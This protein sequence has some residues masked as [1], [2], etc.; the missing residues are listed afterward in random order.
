[1][2]LNI[3]DIVKNPKAPQLGAGTIVDRYDGYIDVVFDGNPDKKTFKLQNNPLQ[4]IDGANST[5]TNIIGENK[6]N[7]P[8]VSDLLR[9]RAERSE[10]DREN[11][12]KI[13]DKAS[14]E[15]RQ[16]TRYIER[17]KLADGPTDWYRE[18]RDHETKS[19]NSLRTICEEPFHAMVEVETY[20]MDR[21]VEVAKEQL[22]YANEN[23]NCNIPFGIDGKSINVLS[24]THPGVQMALAGDL[25]AP[26]NIRDRNYTLLEVIPLARAKFSQVLPDIVGLYEPGGSV[27]PEKHE[28]ASTVLRAVKL[29]MTHDQVKAF[30]SK[31]NGMM[32]VS[33]APGSGKTTVAMQRIRFLFDQGEMRG[34][35][36]PKVEYS[37]P[38]TRIFLANQNLFEHSRQMLEQDLRIPSDVV[39]LVDEFVGD[40]LKEIWIH[41]DS[42]KIRR[43]ELF[44]MEERGRQAFFGLCNSKQLANCWATYE[45]QISE[46]LSKARSSSWFDISQSKDL[47]FE[48]EYLADGF[49]EYAK[50]PTSFGPAESRFDMDS[51]YEYVAKTYENSRNECR[52]E[53]I[54]EKFDSEFQKWLYWVYDPLDGIVSYFQEDFYEGLVRVKKGIGAK[55]HEDDILRGIRQDW[56][57]RVY[58]KEQES[59]LAFLLRFALPTR[60]DV[61]KR[62]REMPNPLDVAYYNG[63]RWTHV[64]I[65]EAQ[66]LC[67]AQAALI[68]SF[69]H[70]DGAFTVSADFHQVVS[71]VWGMN[72]PEAFKMGISL[73]DKGAYQA[74]P[75]AKNMRQSKQIGLFLQ[76]FFEKNFGEMAR[77]ETNDS[78]QDAPPLLILAKAGE[79]PE[80]IAQRFR[81][82]SRIPKIR[83]IAL[84]Q[85]NEDEHA[86]EQLRAALTAQGLDLAPIWASSD[87]KKRLI[88]TSVERIKGLEYDACILIGMDDIENSTLNYSRNRAYVALS[89]PAYQLTVVCREMPEMLR[90]IDKDLIKIVRM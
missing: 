64:M 42:A 55:M 84:L 82:L 69:V 58:G 30:I 50:K 79:I 89:R 87:E 52:K 19:F 35:E 59:W 1:M 76:D 4:K 29:A 48:I 85:I 73:K 36:F 5:K 41:K 8:I 60:L 18:Y 70:P 3:G 32:I 10:R 14:E 13:K 34:E 77:F 23:T 80:K 37:P 12:L 44:R 47:R 65:D 2:E 28:K 7:S 56:K 46:R 88:T 17:T 78:I 68:A 61:Q 21:G 81:L 20:C 72:D 49:I 15:L 90:R 33:G 74:Y 75:F 53:G 11:A 22:W 9:K 71:P 62:F 6:K 83:S 27:G 16:H 57:N 31:M 25:G 54:L 86:M 40:Y 45:K 26:S 43:R 63:R 67:V 39:S 24:W 38:L 66:D 51:V